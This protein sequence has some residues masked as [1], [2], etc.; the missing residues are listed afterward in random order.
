MVTIIV[1]A[2]VGYLLGSIPTGVWLGKAFKGID[3]REHGS[4]SMGAT[5]VFRVLGWRL[6]V[7]TLIIDVAKGFLAALLA[8]K[9]NL[10]DIAL[11]PRQL[12]LIGGLTA[13]IG[14]LY[15]VFAKFKGGKGIAT[16]AGMLLYLVPLELG[17]AVLVF[18]LTVVITRYVSLGSLLASTFLALAIIMERYYLGYPYGEEMITFIILLFA[19]VI[20]THRSNIK[21][22]L[23]GNENKLGAKK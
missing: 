1:V 18:V 2:A 7:L 11:L 8:S 13:I 4:G 3:L 5:N 16:G 6:A 15:P 19:A 22:L 10:G 12:A 17:F 20:F 23:Q 9:I 14:H 21:R